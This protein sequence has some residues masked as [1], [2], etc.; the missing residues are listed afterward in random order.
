MPGQ[1]L[2]NGGYYYINNDNGTIT[3]PSNVSKINEFVF[4][5]FSNN[6][7]I[8][9]N[10]ITEIGADAFHDSKNL[11][12]VINLPFLLTVGLRAFS[13]SSIK[14]FNAP[15]LTT[16]PESCFS[17]SSLESAYLPE[18]RTISNSAMSNCKL[19]ELVLPSIQVLSDSSLAMARLNKII[20]GSNIT[21]IGDFY[22]SISTDTS[23]SKLIPYH[24]HHVCLNT[25][26][27]TMSGK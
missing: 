4:N 10:V 8:G 11:N 17:D 12:G 14:T 3:I 2:C 21:T 18:V 25:T 22:F 19:K 27:P 6:I 15:L 5:N 9:D 20:C 23:L 1:S 24:K 16:I 13:G 7:E 26:P